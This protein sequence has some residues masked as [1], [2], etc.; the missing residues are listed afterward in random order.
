MK[1]IPENVTLGPVQYIKRHG[2]KVGIMIAYSDGTNFSVAASKC[3]IK[4]GDEFSLDTARKIALDRVKH[5]PQRN[6]VLPLGVKRDVVRFVKRL[7]RY[8]KGQGYVD[9]AW[10]PDPMQMESV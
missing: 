6:V 5:D 7:K 9:P 10:Q 2:K 3:N 4:M 1:S 8:Y